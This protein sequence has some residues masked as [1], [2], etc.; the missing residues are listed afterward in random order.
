MSEAKTV[1]IVPSCERDRG[2]GHLR[3]SLFLLRALEEGGGDSYIWISEHHKDDV[4][5]RFKKFFENTGFGK[6]FHARLISRIE[7]INAKKWD[8]IILDRFRTSEKDFAFWASLAPIIGIDEGGPCRK[9]FDFL[10]DLLPGLKGHTANL[11]APGLLPLPKNRKPTGRQAKNKP[12]NILISFGAEDSKGLGPSTARLLA[13]HS[14]SPI[15]TLISNSGEEIPGVHVTGLIADLKE[16]LAEYDLFITHFGIGAFEAVYARVPVLL[17][18]PTDYHYKLSR[19]AGFY[20]IGMGRDLFLTE[21]Q[22]LGVRREFNKIF[23]AGF[24]AELQKRT[25]RIALRYGLEGEQEEDLGSFF[26]DLSPDSSKTCPACGESAGTDNQVL[27]RFP[28]ETYRRC[29]RCGVIYLNRLKPPPFGYDEEYFFDFYK[30]QYGKTYLED[31]P[32]LIQM[33]KRRLKII[34][35]FTVN[36]PEVKPKVLDIGCAYGPFMAASEEMGFSPCGVDPIEDAVRYVN[37]ELGLKAWQGFFPSGAKAEDG[38][39]DAVTLWFVLEHFRDPGK[40]L[41]EINRVLVPGG[42][43]AFSTPSFKGISGRKGLGAFLKNSPADHLTVWSPGIT[44]KILQKYGFKVRKIVV[45]GHHPSRFPFF[46]RFTKLYRPLL[47]ISRFFRLGDT[48]EVYCTK[49]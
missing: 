47:S 13:S 11:S 45:S 20:S 7:E 19:N 42:V 23:K 5:L 4:F 1:L 44:G 18:S 27:A 9:R 8:Y 46:G 49:N 25:E 17:V 38:P 28:E 36:D 10:I 48:F 22:R 21:A 41:A 29:E 43:L 16:M 24:L 15:L 14:S 30:K 33:A 26:G 34:K 6:G 35:N 32:N 31:F 12:L 40:I 2:G 3:R 37:E 39:F